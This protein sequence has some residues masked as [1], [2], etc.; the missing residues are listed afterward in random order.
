MFWLLDQTRELALRAGQASG[1]EN[2]PNI[3]IPDSHCCSP[4]SP[5]RRRRRRLLPLCLLYPRCRPHRLPAQLVSCLEVFFLL[6][7][8]SKRRITNPLAQLLL[9]SVARHLVPTR[10][11]FLLPRRFLRLPPFLLLLLRLPLSLPLPL[12]LP[13]LSPLLLLPP[14]P[15]PLSPSSLKGLARQ[16]RGDGVGK[17]LDRAIVSRARQLFESEVVLRTTVRLF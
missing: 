7:P 11:R 12:R 17:G 4:R 5:P 3:T 14:L 13:L 9:L 10:P 1:A 2:L 6:P 15:R 16:L 8:F